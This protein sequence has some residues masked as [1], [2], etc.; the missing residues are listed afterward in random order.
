[1]KEQ[2][3]AIPGYEAYYEAS[4]FGRIKS[5][6]RKPRNASKWVMRDDPKILRQSNNGYD[7][8]IVQIYTPTIKRLFLVSKLI[9]MTF[10]GPMPSDKNQAA[11]LDGNR[12]N[13]IPSNLIWASFKENDSHKDLHGTRYR[14]ELVYNA[15]L[16]DKDVLN[17]RKEYRI[18]G[19]SQ[20]DLVRK[21]KSSRGS[22]HCIINRKTWRHI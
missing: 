22:I 3:K 2:W 6:Q 14:G 4:S 5:L 15:K 7:Y 10:I 17:I 1:M 9:L 11:H 20:M 16:S 18:G 12:Q 8:H 21:Y 13:N 19:V